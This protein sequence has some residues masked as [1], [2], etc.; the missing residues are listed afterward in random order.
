MKK[1][2]KLDLLIE[3]IIKET[4]L[5][6]LKEGKFSLKGSIA[7]RLR[8]DTDYQKFFKSA[9]AKFGVKTPA[10]IQSD[11][12]KKE[13]FNYVDKNYSAKNEIR[14]PG[15]VS[16]QYRIA[17]QQ[18]KTIM[19]TFLENLAIASRDIQRDF[20][21]L[22]RSA[23]KQSFRQLSKS[24]IDKIMDMLKPILEKSGF[25]LEINDRE[26]AMAF[27]A[28][29]TQT[30]NIDTKIPASILAEA[31][32]PTDSYDEPSLK[33]AKK[34]LATWF[35]NTMINT[36]SPIIRGKLDKQQLDIL[37]DLIDDYAMEY[38]RNYA[39]NIDMERNTF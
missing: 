15:G 16:G 38:A 6:P 23:T 27:R 37:H 5:S 35:G 4:K 21:Q 17:I 29:L 28:A 33:D 8:E 2:N 13:F 31:Y 9:L 12:Q 32:F 18:I 7:K 19:Q 22:Y 36:N 20:T 39:D 25:K 1:E 10:D 14:I 11:E 30:K 3:N 24:E 26:L 34:A